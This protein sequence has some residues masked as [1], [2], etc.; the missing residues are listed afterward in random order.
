MN[1]TCVHISFLL[2]C[3]DITNWHTG[4]CARN[5][6]CPTLI[7]DDNTISDILFGDLVQFHRMVG[8]LS[9]W[10]VDEKVNAVILVFLLWWYPLIARSRVIIN[11]SV[12]AH[13]PHSCTHAL[14]AYTHTHSSIQVQ[15]SLHIQYIYIY[16][17][18]LHIHTY[19][20]TCI[21][22]YIFMTVM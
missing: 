20:C 19:L 6:A 18:T 7:W 22:M 14:C 17:H 5:G 11:V 21:C 4:V 16:T 1:S 9:F 13:G 8:V 12:F 10:T 2:V 3:I 15:T